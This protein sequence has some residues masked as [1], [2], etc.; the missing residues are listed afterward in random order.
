MTIKLT[1]ALVF[2]VVGFSV[3][4]GAVL[5]GLTTASQKFNLYL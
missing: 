2:L 4:A 5:V 3:A 1:G